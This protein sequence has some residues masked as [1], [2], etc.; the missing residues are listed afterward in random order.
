MTNKE[1]LDYMLKELGIRQGVFAKNI[2]VAATSMSLVRSGRVKHFTRKAAAR[3]TAVYPQYSANWIMTGEGPIYTDG[4]PEPE[5]KAEKPARRLR[6]DE[7]EPTLQ[8]NVEMRDLLDLLNK[9]NEQISQLLS[10]IEKSQN[11]E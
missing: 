2:G 8:R 3:I 5:L 4:R 7:I 10:L 1:I 9:Q 11:K 6:S